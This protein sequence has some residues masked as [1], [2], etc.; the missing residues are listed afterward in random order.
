MILEKLVKQFSV[1]I[2]CF[3]FIVTMQAE[4]NGNYEKFY[5]EAQVTENIIDV[6]VDLMSIQ[7]LKGNK[8]YVAYEETFENHPIKNGWLTIELEVDVS[9]FNSYRN[10]VKIIL[11]DEQATSNQINLTQEIVI[12]M[13]AISK[14]LFSRL[15]Q[16]TITGN[17]FP[18]IAGNNGNVVVV[19]DTAESFSY[20]EIETMGDLLGIYNKE[21]SNEFFDIVTENE[22][23]IIII[24]NNKYE[25]ITTKNLFEELG[26]GEISLANRVPSIQGQAN[27]Y[28]QVNSAGSE[29]EIVNTLSDLLDDQIKATSNLFVGKPSQ[30]NSILIYDVDEGVFKADSKDDLGFV[31]DFTNQ[32]FY[33]ESTYELSLSDDNKVSLHELFDNTDNQ[34]LQLNNTQLTL[35]SSNVAVEL[36]TILVEKERLVTLNNELESLVDNSNFQIKNIDLSITNNI[37]SI[38]G[39]TNNIDLAVFLD[40]KDEQQLTYDILDGVLK[41]TNSNSI[42]LIELGS[43]IGRDEQSLTYN[44]SMAILTLDKTSEPPIDLSDLLDN[45]DEQSLSMSG[46]ILSLTREGLADSVVDLTNYFGN[47]ATANIDV[48]VQSFSPILNQLATQ[49]TLSNENIEYGEYMI[50]EAGE[51]GQVWVSDGDG[52]GIWKDIYYLNLIDD[53]IVS[54]ADNTIGIDLTNY[55]QIITL[56]NNNI[57]SLSNNGG[58]IDLN[59]LVGSIGTDD[60]QIEQFDLLDKTLNLEIED[61]GSLKSVDLSSLD[62]QLTN[63]EISDFGFVTTASI[64][65]VK[66]AFASADIALSELITAEYIAANLEQSIMITDVYTSADETILSDITTDYLLADITLSSNLTQAYIAADIQTNETILEAYT[67]ADELVSINITNAYLD[68][69]ETISTNLTAAYQEADSNQRISLTTEYNASD[70]MWV[71][72]LTASYESA[73]TSIQ[74]KIDN[75]SLTLNAHILALTNESVTAINLSTYNQIITFNN[76]ILS[77]SNQGGSINLNDY[78][79]MIG[80]DDQQ[81]E[82]FYLSGKNLNLKIEAGGELKIVDLSVIDTRLSKEEI[83]GFGFVTTNLIEQIITPFQVADS[84]LETTITNLYLEQDQAVSVSLTTAYSLADQTLSTDIT[85]E[86]I[87]ADETLS[88]NITNEYQLADLELKNSIWAEYI[89]ANE[90]Q[91]NLLTEAFV[92]ADETVSI[93]ISAEYIAADNTL[94]VNITNEYQDADIDLENSIWQEYISANEI[95]TSLLSEAFSSAD[96]TVSINITN[97]YIAAD[98]TLLVNIGQAYLSADIAISNNLFQE[99]VVANEQQKTQ[100]EEEYTQA[101]NDIFDLVK[102]DYDSADNNLFDI[103]RAGYESEDSNI[104]ENFSDYYRTQNTIQTD[105]L[106]TNYVSADDTLV[107]EFQEEDNR[108]N[109]LI[110]SIDFSFANNI[111]SLTVGD[112]VI[113]LSDYKQIISFNNDTNQLSISRVNDNDVSID[114]SGI[115]TTLSYAQ[116]VGIISQMGYLIQS[117]LS[118]ISWEHIINVPETWSGC[119]N[120][121]ICDVVHTES[122]FEGSSAGLVPAVTETDVAEYN[123]R[124]LTSTGLWKSPIIDTEIESHGFIKEANSDNIEDNAVSSQKIENEAITS[125]KIVDGVITSAKIK[126]GAITSS[127]IGPNAITDIKIIDGE[128]KDS[129][130]SSISWNKI[131]GRPSVLTSSSTSPSL[132]PVPNTNDKTKYLKGDGTWGDLEHDHPYLETSDHNHNSFLQTTEHH[133]HNSFLQTTQHHNHGDFLL[134]ENTTSTSQYSVTGHQHTNTSCGENCYLRSD[135]VFATPPEDS[136]FEPIGGFVYYGEDGKLGHPKNYWELKNSNQQV[137]L[138]ASC[139]S[140]TY[141]RCWWIRDE[142]MAHNTIGYALRNGWV[143]TSDK[144]LKENIVTINDGLDIIRNIRGTTF[145]NVRN[146][147]LSSQM[148]GFIAQEINDYIPEVVRTEK[149]DEKDYFMMSYEPIT[150]I[151]IE[152]IKQLRAEKNDDILDITSKHQNNYDQYINEIEILKKENKKIKQEIEIII[153]RINELAIMQG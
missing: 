60:Q 67:S 71:D 145:Q 7:I 109:T 6:T 22:N 5:I 15:A 126:N 35:S 141:T 43:E 124:Y 49:E 108:L 68:A 32:L 11:T 48:D 69:D 103:L 50:D 64:T 23:N 106:I 2:L 136:G 66:E 84:N 102:S 112:S 38:V 95:Q 75:L 10:W 73:D 152:G 83:S 27:K 127:K 87:A 3:F 63:Q 148:I 151:I 57:V 91:S 138:Y 111:L 137:T 9:I 113:D 92:S 41:L 147:E 122:I 85:T 96:E 116:V 1:I 4:I 82:Q 62:T 65:Q 47:V 146:D 81:I 31:S 99:Y 130:L 46:G 52:K 25:K 79:D 93:N 128:I 86:Y 14:S 100:L 17:L 39:T 26:L 58:S 20:L 133:N 45:T 30:E 131:E 125:A 114:L 16:E 18:E 132:I 118:D 105:Q 144:R 117:D 149:K 104:L 54:L 29:F 51:A 74:N 13:N 143:G 94:A 44:Q 37:L 153:K 61:G 53:N 76:N 121:G 89:S 78:V 72:V 150:A 123:T 140:N 119:G 77:L 107:A 129:N 101:D 120:G 80:S 134:A 8:N 98:E 33:D 139:N 19:N 42:S 24:S 40:N 115:D 55:T 34:D 70:N 36:A 56:N 97:A 135:G 28:L 88:V 12:T 142:V 21:Q 59:T 90:I 110:D